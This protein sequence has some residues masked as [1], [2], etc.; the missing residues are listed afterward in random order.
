MDYYVKIPVFEGPFD[1]LY[2]L[3]SKAEV[4]I[5]EISV[6]EITRQ[7]LNYL[8]EMQELN[9]EIASE[10]LVIAA[11]LLRLKSKLLLPEQ[12]KEEAFDEDEQFSEI[13]SKE[14]LLRR[15][16]AYRQF[17]NAA[18]ILAEKEQNQKRIF[19]RSTSGSRKVVFINRQGFFAAYPGGILAE[20][21]RAYMEK[22]AARQNSITIDHSEKISITTIMQEIQQLLAKRGTI[23]FDKLC[24]R[25]SRSKIAASFFAVLQLAKQ[26]IVRLWQE[27]N[28]GTLL[29]VNTGKDVDKESRYG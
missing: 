1:L 3:V 27:K 24:Y 11:A 6:A 14:E 18:N 10:F 23:S 9:L 13:D 26:K 7:Y 2:H 12:K 28:F 19:L 17:K 5:W 20:I 8:Q 16:I 22:A 29:V 25:A 21:M 15:L 4:D